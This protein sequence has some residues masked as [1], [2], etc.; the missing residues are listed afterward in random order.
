MEEEDED[1]FDDDEEE[2]NS[3]FFP[4]EEEDFSSF[5]EEDCLSC[6]EGEDTTVEGPD[7]SFLWALVRTMGLISTAEEAASSTG[8]RTSNG[9]TFFSP[10]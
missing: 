8:R 6:R 9:N 10:P 1:F 7:N 5:R 2:E 4:E 3:P